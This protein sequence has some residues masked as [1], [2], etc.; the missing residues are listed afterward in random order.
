[1][2]HT[3]DVFTT[4]APIILPTSK[5]SLVKRNTI[6]NAGVVEASQ[7]RVWRESIRN[8]RSL[9]DI[10]TPYSVSSIGDTANKNYLRMNR[11]FQNV[12][13]TEQKLAHQQKMLSTDFRSMNINQKKVARKEL[14]LE[15][16]GQ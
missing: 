5:K 15:L 14:F 12:H 16:R 7:T 4:S 10:F 8:V 3:S 2:L 11:K 9:A 1:M 13:V 6:T